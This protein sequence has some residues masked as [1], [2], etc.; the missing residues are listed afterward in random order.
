MN[1]RLK[2]ETMATHHIMQDGQIIHL[3]GDVEPNQRLVN[4]VWCDLGAGANVQKWAA[5]INQKP[6][7]I[8]T[9]EIAAPKVYPRKNVLGA[10]QGD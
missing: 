8:K 3:R 10:Y 5:R 9:V 1:T 6:T 2:P 7:V 4:G